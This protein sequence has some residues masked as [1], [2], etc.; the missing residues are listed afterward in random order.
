[1]RFCEASW[2]DASDQMCV[3]DAGHGGVHID[4]MNREWGYVAKGAW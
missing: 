4:A 1:M 3:R 2:G